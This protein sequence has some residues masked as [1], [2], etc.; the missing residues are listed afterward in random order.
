MDDSKKTPQA[1]IT[2]RKRVYDG[3]FKVDEL[4]INMGMHN[5]GSM[6]IKRLIFERGH[7]VAILGY[8]PY[9]D[10]VLLINE[11]HPGL[12]AAGEYPFI[13]SLPAGMIDE[14][15]AVLEAAA[16]EFFEETGAQLTSAKVIHSGAY[17]SSGG[18]SEKITLVVGTLDMT[19]VVSGSI[20]GITAEGEDIRV[21]V[22]KADDYIARAESGQLHDMKCMVFALWLS[23]NRDAMRPVANG[24]NRMPRVE[25]PYS[26]RAPVRIHAKPQ[27]TLELVEIQGTGR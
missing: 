22:V 7:A 23:K 11:M 3:F 20:H 6:E 24:N 12:L 14:G 15:E 19:K 9:T 4:T 1:E 17:V 26:R 2:E 25:L 21:S 18:T 27:E 13:D 10:E 8:D 16:R 5:G